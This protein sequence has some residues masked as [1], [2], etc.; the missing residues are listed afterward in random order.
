MNFKED[1]KEFIRDSIT[2]AGKILERKASDIADDLVK[3]RVTGI[4]ITMNIT[5][6]SMPELNIEKTYAAIIE[7]KQK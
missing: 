6:D 5:P 2:E 4:W 7:Q 3:E 1:Q